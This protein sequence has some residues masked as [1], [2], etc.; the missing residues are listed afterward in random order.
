MD[1]VAA[2]TKAVPGA[3]VG[4]GTGL[5]EALGGPFPQI[6]SCPIGEID[7]TNFR[8]YLALPPI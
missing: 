8:D 3:T 2:I 4:V 5:V 7:A 6:R 1:A